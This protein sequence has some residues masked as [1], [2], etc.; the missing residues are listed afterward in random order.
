MPDVCIKYR[1][2]FGSVYPT[3]RT[4]PE[5]TLSDFQKSKP[6]PIRGFHKPTQSDPN[7]S[8]RFDF[9]GSNVHP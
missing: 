6:Y 3:Q 2:R 5:P 8:D 9:Y 4:G 1:V 7:K